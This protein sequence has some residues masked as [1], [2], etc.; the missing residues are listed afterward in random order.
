MT[1]PPIFEYKNVYEYLDHLKNHGRRRP[2]T[3]S[4]LA[5]LLGYDSPRT[6][7]MAWTKKRPLSKNLLS[8]IRIMAKL[9][10]KQYV[11][12]ELL[13]E[14]EKKNSHIEVSRQ[15]Q[16][17]ATLAK[18]YRKK[19]LPN[20]VFSLI[21][22]WQHAAL[23]QLLQGQKSF[24]AAALQKKLRGHLSVAA[25]EQA[26][27]NLLSL[28][29]LNY[30]ANLGQFTETSENLVVGQ[31]IPSKAIVAYHQQLLTLAEA[32]LNE[33][34]VSDRDFTGHTLRFNP[35]KIKE[36]RDFI[37]NFVQE[38]NAEFFDQSASEI[39]QLNVQLFSHTKPGVEMTEGTP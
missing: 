3:Y 26:I 38:F 24:S 25:I 31:D 34:L 10:P 20:R 22:D 7:A 15:V 13:A 30:D 6:V 32:A 21:S 27:E 2:L 39:Y 33:Q 12:L 35:E 18:T 37:F 16:E 4:Q 28:K 1:M 9:T 17:L 14:K 19:S 8:R 36:A 11:Y 29:I 23:H 5:K